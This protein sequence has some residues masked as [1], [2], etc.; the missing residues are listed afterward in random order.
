MRRPFQYADTGGH[1]AVEI[2]KGRGGNSRSERRC[3]NTVVCVK[4]EVL[5]Q[6]YRI[7]RMR[8]F[9]EEAI[10]E[11]GGV[12]KIGRRRNRGKAWSNPMMGRDYLRCLC[13]GLLTVE[14][15]INGLLEG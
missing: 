7:F 10:K 4:K 14:E 13:V 6:Q 11:I 15:Q 9:S 5:I 8:F 3:V 1:G 12:G 2:G